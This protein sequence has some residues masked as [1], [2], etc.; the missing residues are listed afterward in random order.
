MEPLT[1]PVTAAQRA[2]GLSE[3]LRIIFDQNTPTESETISH[4]S[5]LLRWALVNSR[6]YSEA[7]PL[8]WACPC[9]PL[10]E[11]MAK[12]SPER[13]QYYANYVTH[14]MVV[15]HS[16]SQKDAFAENGLLDGLVF[17][18]LT[19]IFADIYAPSAREFHE[20]FSFY[21]DNFERLVCELEGSTI[22]DQVFLPITKLM[23][24]LR[25]MGLTYEMLLGEYVDC[26]YFVGEIQIAQNNQTTAPKNLHWFHRDEPFEH[27][28][29][30]AE[31]WIH[32]RLGSFAR[33]TFD[34]TYEVIR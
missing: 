25:K 27:E 33:K 17:P 11:I 29:D 2:L 24:G 14:A 19:R 12:P 34:S 16:Q 18:K 23:P 5:D 13:R 31:D 8:L 28:W 7:I 15:Y 30:G 3:I 22:L 1:Q 10:D 21:M 9:I 32:M 4:H 26:C 20:R 6:W